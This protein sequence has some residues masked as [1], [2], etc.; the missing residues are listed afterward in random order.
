MKYILAMS[1][2]INGVALELFNSKEELLKY[3][4][5]NEWYLLNSVDWDN[6]EKYTNVEAEYIAQKPEFFVPNSEAHLRVMKG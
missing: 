6:L 2:K 5:E 1:N 3:L 4:N